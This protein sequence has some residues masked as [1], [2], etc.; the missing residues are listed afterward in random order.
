VFKNEAQENIWILRLCY[1]AVTGLFGPKKKVVAG[2]WRRLHNEEL[3]N[4]YALANIVRVIKSRRL[5]LTGHVERNGDMI[6]A[7]NISV[8]RPEGKRP[9]V[10]PTHRWEDDIRKDLK[11]IW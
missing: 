5:R 6:S 11:E 7:Y 1:G 3:H 8:R 9:F 2:D 4:L 10:R